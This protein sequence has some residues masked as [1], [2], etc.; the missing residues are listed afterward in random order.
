MLGRNEAA[1]IL[2]RLQE[3]G[4]CSVEDTRDRSFRSTVLPAVSPQGVVVFRYSRRAG[5]PVTLAR[6]T[7]LKNILQ[8]TRSHV[9]S[10]AY[11][12]TFHLC[13]LF[14]ILSF[15]FCGH[16]EVLLTFVRIDSFVYLLL[17]LSSSL[18]FFLLFFLVAR[19]HTRAQENKMAAV[20]RDTRPN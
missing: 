7:K 2:F 1:T 9:R 17:L 13:S 14:A 3:I 12:S 11:Y 16:D 19:S 20:R 15:S 8:L 5:S 18:F 4:I 6:V 10:L